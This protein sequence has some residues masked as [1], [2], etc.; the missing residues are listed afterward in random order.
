M[1]QYCEIDCDKLFLSI[2]G[3]AWNDS[4]SF[5]EWFCDPVQIGSMLV[6]ASLGSVDVWSGPPLTLPLE[7]LLLQREI[8]FRLM[9]AL[10]LLKSVTKKNIWQML[11]WTGH[12]LQTEQIIH[13][14]L[15]VKVCFRLL[16]NRNYD[17][18]GSILVWHQFEISQLSGR[19]QFVS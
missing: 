11:S 6:R 17:W 8:V 19:D 14:L 2:L 9:I 4:G 18:I 5:A 12:R 10:N 15:Q 1:R 7:C 3:F 13:P 16:R